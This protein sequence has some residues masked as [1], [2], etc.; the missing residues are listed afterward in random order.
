MTR[1]ALIV[2]L[3]PGTPP[4]I[5]P[6]DADDDWLVALAVH[7]QADVICTRNRD[8]FHADVLAYCR[9]QG[10]EVMNDLDLLARLRDD[11]QP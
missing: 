2:A 7:G 9:G 1:T 4:R 11:A 8:L 6:G 5:V 10:V 3:P